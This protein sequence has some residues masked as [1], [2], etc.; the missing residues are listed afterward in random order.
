MYPLILGGSYMQTGSIFYN[1]YCLCLITNIV[2]KVL[3]LSICNDTF[4]MK[5]FEKGQMFTTILGLNLPFS[6][7]IA[8]T[9]SPSGPGP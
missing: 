7:H 8:C 4:Q 3:G 2:C 6:L 9:V 1:R 5:L